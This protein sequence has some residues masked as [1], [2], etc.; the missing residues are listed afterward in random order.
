M[1]VVLYCFLISLLQLVLE[2]APLLCFGVGIVEVDCQ[3]EPKFCM[4]CFGLI[5]DHFLLQV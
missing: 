1:F 4:L 3:M 2:L 5:T